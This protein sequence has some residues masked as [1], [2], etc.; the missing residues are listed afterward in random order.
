MHRLENLETKLDQEMFEIVRRRTV[1]EFPARQTS[2]NSDSA[3]A[4]LGMVSEAAEAIRRF[5]EEAAEA[6]NR[7]HHAAEAVMKKL[8]I[9]HTRAEHA[10][11][12]QHRAE[13]QVDEVTALAA[14]MR[15]ELETLQT[16]LAAKEA[17]LEA[18]ERRGRHAEQRA[19]EA[20]A[21]IERIAEAIRTQLPVAS[22][23]SAYQKTSSAA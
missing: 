12:A 8:D 1:V 21:A 17:E 16:R 10:E 14:K 9:A 20:D 23:A 18:A 3:A 6:I 15:N 13:A 5:E 19:A 2:V 22:G 7:A 11:E 4:A